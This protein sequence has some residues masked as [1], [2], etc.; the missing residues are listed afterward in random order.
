MAKSTTTHD[1]AKRATAAPPAPES[2][3]EASEFHALMMNRPRRRRKNPFAAHHRRGRGFRRNPPLSVGGIM[4]GVQDGAAGCTRAAWSQRKFTGAVNGMLTSATA[5]NPLPTAIST[6]GLRL[7]AAVGL[8]IVTPKFAPKFA[9]MVTAGAFSET[10]ASAL[11]Q[12][13]VAP[14][15]GAMPARRFVASVPGTRG[16]LSR[17]RGNLGSAW[18]EQPRRPTSRGAGWPGGSARVARR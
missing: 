8:G 17:E 3:G 6:V 5:T 9:R 4:Q 12:T 2:P 14:Y 13:P 11:A 15:L 10:I 18:R 16:L 1:E 7:V